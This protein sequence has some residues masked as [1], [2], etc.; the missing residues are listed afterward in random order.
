[1][2]RFPVS[3]CAVLASAVLLTA[4]APKSA[5]APAAAGTPEAGVCT[6]VYAEGVVTMDGKQ[7][8]PGTVILDGALLETDAAGH[9]EMVF[10][11]KNIIKMG[12]ATAM[13]LEMKTL[14]RVVHV[15]SGTFTAVLRKLDRLAGGTLEVRTPNAVAGV[16]GTS[17]F[18]RYTPGDTQTYF[19]T[20]NGTLSMARSDGT[21]PLAKTANHHDST[22]YAGEAASAVLLPIPAGFNFGHSDADLENLAAKI[23]EKID[24]TAAE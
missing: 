5:A 3:L 2:K 6:L 11:D 10:N 16:R 1:M 15:E 22:V 12:P 7:I 13:R 17:F 18:A 14:Q 8:E 23:G 9:A 20:C 19:C 21:L 4:C 24:W